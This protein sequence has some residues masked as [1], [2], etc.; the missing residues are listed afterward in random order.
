MNIQF[1]E[2]KQIKKKS[3]YLCSR[4]NVYKIEFLVLSNNKQYF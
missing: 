1:K 2:K 4:N 3:T